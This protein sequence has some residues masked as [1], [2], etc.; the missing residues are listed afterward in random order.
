MRSWLHPVEV[1]RVF[2][3]FSMQKNPP[4]THIYIII[5]IYISRQLP[6]HNGLMWSLDMVVINFQSLL[7]WFI[8]CWCS[9]EAGCGYATTAASVGGAFV[10]PGVS[11]DARF[12]AHAWNLQVP[13]LSLKH[14]KALKF[15]KY[16]K[17]CAFTRVKGPEK[18][19]SSRDGQ[20]TEFHNILEWS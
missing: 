1:P 8:L 14:P 18:V 15:P 19:S 11:S 17:I 13:F 4:H 7:A 12:V 20:R 10:P 2:H 6:I 3:C 5:Y 16:I 9:P